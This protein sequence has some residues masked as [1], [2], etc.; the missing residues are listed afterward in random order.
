[1]VEVYDDRISIVSPG[2]VPKGITS[3][4]F[5][6]RSVARNPIIADLLRRTHYIEKAGTGIGRMRELMKEAGLRE[7]YFQYDNFFEVTFS[8]PSYYDENYGK[9]DLSNKENYEKEDIK[10]E[11]NEIEKII[12]ERFSEFNNIYVDIIKVILEN[13]YVT[14]DEIAHKLNKTR[15]SVARNL[16]TLK[17]KNIIKREGS[18]KKGYWK[19]L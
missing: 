15:S 16:K 14:Q 2:G 9:Y 13:K 7:P 10:I 4:N 3:E 19:I 17:D 12:K 8:R 6:K 1:M 18:N 11:E 5:G